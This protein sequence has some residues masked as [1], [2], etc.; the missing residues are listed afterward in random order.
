MLTFRKNGVYQESYEVVVDLG[1]ASTYVNASIG[2]KITN[3]QFSASQLVTGC[4]ASLNNLS[5]AVSGDYQGTSY[6][7]YPVYTLWVTVPRTNNAVRSTDVSRLD[8]LTQNTVRSKIDS[9]LLN[10]AYISQN[11]GTSNQF[12]TTTLVRESIATYPNNKLSVWMA[13]IVDPTQ[14][15]LNDTWPATEP[16]SGNLE[17]TTSSSFSGSVRSDLY[18][19]RPLT[20]AHGNPIVDPH[21]GTSG[22]AYY[23][24]YFELTSAGALTFTREA[25][26]APVPPAP[27]IVQLV[28][29]GSSSTVYFT[30][31]NGPT[32][33]L[34]YTN[35][36][37]LSAPVSTWPASATTVVG[38]GNTNSISDTTSDPARFYRVGAH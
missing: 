5:W 29:S 28:R 37:G 9:I 38:N 36:T 15:T 7:G 27:Q 23:V 1:Q 31:T 16:N 17:N 19:V 8:R 34:Y 18:E 4:F 3:T 26:A 13:G 24:G 32:Y 14:G 12:N 33:T 35:S 21:T 10:A 30:T 22:L 20:D 25:A 11:L 6:P 2:T